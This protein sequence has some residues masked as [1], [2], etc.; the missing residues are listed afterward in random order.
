[1]VRSVVNLDEAVERD[2]E[3][4]ALVAGNAFCSDATD[5]SKALGPSPSISSARQVSRC[6]NAGPA[7]LAPQWACIAVL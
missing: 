7:F 4:L 5:T 1:L 3:I 2:L 6:A